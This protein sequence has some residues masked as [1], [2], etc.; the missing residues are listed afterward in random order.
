MSKLL[1][2]SD[3]HA[4]PYRE[5]SYYMD[6]GLNSRFNDCLQCLSAIQT[7]FLK[8]ECNEMVFLG[9]I[10]HLKDGVSSTVIRWITEWLHGWAEDWPITF[11]CGNHDYTMWNKSP[12]M[13]Q[14]L[15]HLGGNMVTVSNGFV[16]RDSF[17]FYIEDYTRAVDDLNACLPTLKLDR[18]TIFLAHQDLIG[19]QYGG[20]IN[21]RG[22]DPDFL[23]KKFAWS[24]VG[25]YH[26]SEAVRENVIS[27]G[28]PLPHNFSD[29]HGDRGWWILDTETNELKFCKNDFSPQFK[30][31]ILEKDQRIDFDDDKNFYRIK[32]RG[33]GDRPEGLERLKWA[34]VSYESGAVGKRR[35]SISVS[36]KKEDILTK[37]VEMKAGDLDKEKLL[38]VGR[39]FL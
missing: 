18:K 22:L 4:H 2:W 29:M 9:D 31:I 38:E 6:Q 13:V 33:T 28:A 21:Q 8:N 37:Y 5:F 35:S 1:I 15:E 26:K 10:Y 30:E 25:H 19:S 12:A 27:C 34:R 36:D 24:F 39:R 11:V 32:V 20:I 16:E 7:S 23:S 3:L 17:D 14:L